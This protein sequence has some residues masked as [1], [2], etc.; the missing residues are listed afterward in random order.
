MVRCKLT[1]NIHSYC[2]KNVKPETRTY[3]RMSFISWWIHFTSLHA[4]SKSKIIIWIQYEII[5]DVGHKVPA[6]LS[7]SLTQGTKTSIVTLMID[8][9][10]MVNAIQKKNHF[11]IISIWTWLPNTWFSDN[12]WLDDQDQDHN[13]MHEFRWSYFDYM[14]FYR[15]HTCII[16]TIKYIVLK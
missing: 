13:W 14:I 9:S 3:F 10:F 4:K 1:T 6:K 2:L 5:M 11:A 7:R 16:Y 15:S 8:W 12:K